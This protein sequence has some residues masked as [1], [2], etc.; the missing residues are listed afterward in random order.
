LSGGWTAVI[1]PRPAPSLDHSASDVE[2]LGS[3]GSSGAAGG[4]RHA[5]HHRNILPWMHCLGGSGGV[6]EVEDD[7]FRDR[8]ASRLAMCD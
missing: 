5:Y 1:V 2:L 4:A 3:G 6:L 7:A 8:W